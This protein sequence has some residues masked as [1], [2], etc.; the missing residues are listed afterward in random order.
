VT[1][2]ER[3]I[4]VTRVARITGLDRTRVEVACAVRPLGHVLQVSNGKGWTFE[5]ARASAVAEAAELWAA[6]R[7]DA[8][9]LR[10]AT[11]SEMAE[12]F[13]RDAAWDAAAL[14]SAGALCAP[15]LW[16]QQTRVAWRSAKNLTGR[17]RVWVPAQAVHCLPAEAPPLGPA[18]VRWSSNG[19]GAHPQL[20]KAIEH[21]LLEVLERDR[22]ARALPRGFTAAALRRRLVEPRTLPG[23][24]LGRVREL[25]QRG[26]DVHFLAL[27]NAP[28]CVACLLVD[29]ERGPVGLTAGYACRRKPEAAAGAALLEAAQSRLTDIHGAREDVAPADP[30]QMATLRR[31]LTQATPRRSFSALSSYRGPLRRLFR[32]AAIVDLAPPGLR[33]HVVKVIAPQ[34]LVSEL[35]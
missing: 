6:E 10:Y 15:A 26:F 24:L 7:V 21:A 28:P 12:R 8:L 13:G 9:E 2:L 22:L 33:L 18:V 20:S 30:E 1:A 5:A 29:R 19:M 11:R 4:G 17:G 16:S 25:G 3:R 14:G 27:G 35:L 34:M 23:R 32:R 31:L